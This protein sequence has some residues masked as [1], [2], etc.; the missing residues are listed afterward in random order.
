LEETSNFTAEKKREAW[1]LLI[2]NR[3][4]NFLHRFMPLCKGF[5]DCNHTDFHPNGF[6]TYDELDSHVVHYHSNAYARFNHDPSCERSKK[7]RCVSTGCSYTS[8]YPDRVSHHY[9]VKHAFHASDGAL[10][11][12][13]TANAKLEEEI[14]M[15]TRRREA[16]TT[17]R[18]KNLRLKVENELLGGF[19]LASRIKNFGH[20]GDLDC[21]AILSLGGY[22]IN[23]KSTEDECS[24]AYFKLSSELEG[25]L[26]ATEILEKAW[27][28]YLALNGKTDGGGRTPDHLAS[29][30]QI[31]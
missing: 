26:G 2:L 27:N 8:E 23:D 13:L 4:D 11:E 16:I 22:Q 21:Y 6:K 5:D 17:E 12:L 24:N 29:G 15:K 3:Q 30:I 9:D 7:W 20:H 25:E 10:A 14:N 28:N 1:N 18:I 31:V 19:R